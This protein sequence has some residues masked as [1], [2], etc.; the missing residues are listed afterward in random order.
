MYS[1][2][3]N[4]PES[5]PQKKEKNEYFFN[6]HKISALRQNEIKII[7]TKDIPSHFCKNKE[8]NNPIKIL[9]SHMGLYLFICDYLLFI[10]KDAYSGQ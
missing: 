9:S 2:I 6:I 4:E 10:K 7:F 5:I 1:C 3:K 8:G